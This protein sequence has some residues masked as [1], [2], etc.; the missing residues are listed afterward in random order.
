MASLVRCMNCLLNEL[1]TKVQLSLWSESFREDL[2]D[3]ST[4]SRSATH[5]RSRPSS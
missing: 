2:K 5:L 3:F 1:K 4:S